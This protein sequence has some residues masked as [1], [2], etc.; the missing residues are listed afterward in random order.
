MRDLPLVSVGI[1]FRNA[2]RTLGD[3]I[4]SVLR[5]TH[6]NL[7]LILVDDGSTDNSIEVAKTFKDSRI[8]I[9]SDGTHLNLSSRLNQIIAMSRGKY[10]A[11]MD[12]DDLCSHTRIERQVAYLEERADVDV[13]GTGMCYLDAG[14]HP[15]GVYSPPSDHGAIC[16]RLPR[17]VGL[18]H[19]TVVGRKAWFEK[20]R[21][22]STVMRA[23]D[24]ELWIRSYASS[25]FANV[26]D[27]LYFYRVYQSYN[28]RNQ[29]KA[30][31]EAGWF[32]CRY[33][34]QNG[35]PLGALRESAVQTLKLA[36]IAGSF[37]FGS[38]QLF[39]RRRFEPLSGETGAMIE[40]EIGLI[41]GAASLAVDTGG[42]PD[43]DT[44]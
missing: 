40:A 19:A 33:Y 24:I 28:L 31:T 23:E 14:G 18:A 32:S 16:A 4:V 11:R 30:R 38:R 6:D 8:R 10:I 29:L 34:L 15:V 1:P 12:A 35:R 39:V 21:Y 41:S 37:A 3:A 44:Q 9:E 5:Q 20:N 42:P 17:G 13:V 7:E 27:P 36:A 26:P 25:T 43:D 22:D 2:S